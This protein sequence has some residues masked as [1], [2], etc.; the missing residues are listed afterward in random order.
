M[1]SNPWLLRPS[2]NERCELRLFC[3]P[4]AGGG[5]SVYMSW[6]RALAPSVDLCAI[7][8]PGRETRLR[9]RPYTGLRE[10][11][12]AT[13]HALRPYLD[14][15]F[16]LLGHSMG[17]LIAFELARRLRLEGAPTPR[18][19]IVS[20]HRAPQLP[21]P[22]PPITHLPDPEFLA[23]IRQRYDGVPEEVL[24]HGDL[25]ALLLPGLRADMALIERYAYR[26]EAPL[27]C[28]ISAY[29]G[30]HDPEA[31]EQELA[32]W[33]AHT[34]GAFALELFPGN[35]FFIRSAGAEV[36]TSLSRELAEIAETTAGVRT[37]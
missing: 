17:A 26:D 15:P 24:R 7:Q 28:A 31:T 34:R 25:M 27:N 18:R 6:S 32:A 29:G 14:M 37:S 9:E 2:A 30:R 13:F 16:V 5:A 23:E 11:L 36:V 10:L 35:H 4:Y 33:Q 21:S 3:F 12:N 8:F 20:G 22:H 19:L 1:P